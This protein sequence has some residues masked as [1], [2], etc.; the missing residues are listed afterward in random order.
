MLGRLD[1]FAAHKGDSSN[2]RATIILRTSPSRTG[3]NHD[4][5]CCS[6]PEFEICLPGFGTGPKEK[7]RRKEGTKDTEKKVI[8]TEAQRSRSSKLEKVGALVIW[9]A[10]FGK[11]YQTQPP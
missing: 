6:R 7:K 1:Y 10:D 9:D 2:D 4:C 5:R 8:T 3:T 11:T